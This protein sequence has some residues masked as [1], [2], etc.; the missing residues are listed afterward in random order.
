MEA[1]T[2]EA[3]GKIENG[4]V[5]VEETL[6]IHD[7]RDVVNNLLLIIFL[8][9]RVPPQI[10]GQPRASAADDSDPQIRRFEIYVLLLCHLSD[11][12]KRPIRDIYGHEYA[13]RLMRLN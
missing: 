4:P 10:V 1:L 11:L 9:R 13:K 8:H 7:D 12:G 6:E 3:V 2:V 5:D